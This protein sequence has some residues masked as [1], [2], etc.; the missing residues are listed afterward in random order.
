MQHETLDISPVFTGLTRPA[1][2]FGVT[3][4]YLGLSAMATL[5]MVILLNN[6]LIGL[7]Y[8]PLHIFGFIVCWQDPFAFRI[9]LK[10]A[11][12]TLSPNKKRWGCVSYEPY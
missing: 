6:P 8:V 4:E 12:F 7:M 11:E 5:C 10:R 3:F 2:K 1:M 9:L